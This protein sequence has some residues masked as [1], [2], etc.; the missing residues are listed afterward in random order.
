MS[1]ELIEKSIFKVFSA[2]LTIKIPIPTKAKDY[3]ILLDQFA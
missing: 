3:P 2:K 1:G